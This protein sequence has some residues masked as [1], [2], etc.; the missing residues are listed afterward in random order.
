[1]HKQ[2]SLRRRIIY[3]YI[4]FSALICGVFVTIFLF[5]EEYVE[6]ELIYNRL[7]AELEQQI[8]NHQY[9]NSIETIAGVT[10]YVGNEIPGHLEHL[11]VD[12]LPHEVHL[13]DREIT[14][15]L[16]QKGDLTYAVSA[17]LEHFETIEFAVAVALA[18]ATAVSLLLSVLFAIG[19][20]NRVIG[21]LKSLTQK[22]VSGTLQKT[23]VVSAEDEI[24][25]LLKAILDRDVQLSG[26]ISREK[27]FTGDVSHELRTP[28]TIILGASEVLAARL[29]A[30]TIAMEYVER[31]LYTAH[32]TSERITALLLLSRSPDAISATQARLAPL[33]EKEIDRYRYLLKNKSVICQPVLKAGVTAFVRVELAG[34]AFGNLVRNA[35]QY[36]DQGEVMIQLSNT[37]LL[38]RDSGCGVPREIQQHVFER[39][40][41]GSDD[42]LS[43]SGLGLSIVK[44]VCEHVGWKLQYQSRP[45]GGSEFSISFYPGETP[46]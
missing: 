29:A 33:I 26:F 7:S 1:M 19:T 45:A 12:G 24:G 37:G 21:P 10:F 23:D 39:F 30:D 2:N 44:R 14:A 27:L 18:I 46:G 34:I 32:D 16:Q 38:I 31:I 11:P 40:V 5:A 22:V 4:A 28:L 13:N 15:L 8:Q 42:E 3:S 36:T 43:G 9:G 41:R 25:V 17:G 35:F 6:E 20:V